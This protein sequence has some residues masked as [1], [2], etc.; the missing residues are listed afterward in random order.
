MSVKAQRWL[1]VMIAVVMLATV[2]STLVLARSTPVIQ[3]YVD[4]EVAKWEAVDSVYLFDNG[5][6]DDTDYLLLDLLPSA[7][8]SKG[9]V[10]FIGDSQSRNALMPWLLSPAERELIHN[11][12][13]GDLHHRDQR[14][15]IK[16]LVEEMGLL[17]GGAD[18]TTIILGISPNM[19]RPRDY[20]KASYVSSSFSR[21]GLFTYTYDEGIHRANISDLERTW[22]VERDRVSRF[23]N[24]AMGTR[25]SRVLPFNPKLQ[26]IE[27]NTEGD[28]WRESMDSEVIELTQ[29]LDYLQARHVRVRAIMRPSGSW[30]KQLPYER[31]YLEL[32]KP[33]LA[34]RNVPLIDQSTLLADADFVDDNHVKYDVQL[35]LH[36]LDREIARHELAEMGLKLPAPQSVD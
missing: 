6:V 9:G 30:K 32:V 20:H 34:A 27:F 1:S 19:T 36:E 11:Y 29:L 18:K 16:M 24:I 22:H 15:F 14:L 10:F 31:T 12:S 5:Y 21:H 23:V 28:D 17:D 2:A 7:D 13:V 35:K 4:R 3:N 26:T 8:H 25:K 33:V